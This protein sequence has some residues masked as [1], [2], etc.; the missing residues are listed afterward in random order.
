MDSFT[1]RHCYK[2]QGGNVLFV[3]GHVEWCDREAY[4]RLTSGL[5][6]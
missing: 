1:K 4:D 3:D 6:P 2:G 5:Q